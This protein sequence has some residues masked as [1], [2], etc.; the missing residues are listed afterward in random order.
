MPSG[1]FKGERLLELGRGPAIY[2]LIAA[3][4][5]FSEIVFS[6]YTASCREE[7]RKWIENREDAY[8]WS[9]HFKFVTDMIGNRSVSRLFYEIIDR[10]IVFTWI[11]KKF[12]KM[13][14]Q[15]ITDV[16]PCDVLKSNPLEPF[17]YDTF[18]GIIVASCLEMACADIASF[19]NSVKSVASLLKPGGVVVHWGRLG[20]N[21]YNVG[22]ASFHALTTTEEIVRNAYKQAGFSIIQC[23]KVGGGGEDLKHLADA[24][25]YLFMVASK[26]SVVHA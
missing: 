23:V 21:F 8:D 26:H 1:L 16:V 7:V 3:T 4:T 24:N 9:R 20:G 22:D 2:R 18:D 5:H 12:K 11:G 17:T 14:R 6:D 25:N 19:R 15:K 13:L 10:H